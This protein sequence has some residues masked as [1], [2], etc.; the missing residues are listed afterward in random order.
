M[1]VYNP[2]LN[3][4]QGRVV[5]SVWPKGIA[6]SFVLKRTIKK[7]LWTNFSP[8]LIDLDIFFVFYI[9][10]KHV[11]QKSLHKQERSFDI[12]EK[13]NW[14][15]K[16][17]TKRTILYSLKIMRIYFEIFCY[18]LYKRLCSFLSVLSTQDNCLLPCYVINNF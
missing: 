16:L 4:I 7:E 8:V 18:K 5:S 17:G 12:L 15:F 6:S 2:N 10:I 11:Q 3:N 1:L 9:L 14:S 13:W